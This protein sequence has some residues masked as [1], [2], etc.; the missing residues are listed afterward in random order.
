[1]TFRKKRM[2]MKLNTLQYLQATP[3]SVND[4]Q[5]SSSQQCHYLWPEDVVSPLKRWSPLKNEF[6]NFPGV[7]FTCGTCGRLSHYFVSN[8]KKNA[9]IIMTINWPPPFV[10]L[11]VW[12]FYLPSLHC[13]CWGTKK[14]LQPRKG[15]WLKNVIIL[16]CFDHIRYG[17]HYPIAIKMQ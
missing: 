6:C 1:M 17:T 14:I 10:A 15:F 16:I 5:T 13:V 12:L 11:I 4:F 2:Y 8:L 9:A 3:F 7:S